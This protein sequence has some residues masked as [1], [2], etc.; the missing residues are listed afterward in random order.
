MAQLGVPD[1]EEVEGL[2]QSLSYLQRKQEGEAVSNEKDR[3][4]SHA[5]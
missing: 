2:Q 5:T 1:M 3:K 4:I